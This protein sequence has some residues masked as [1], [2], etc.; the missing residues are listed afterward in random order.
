MKD[1]FP[2]CLAAVLRYEGGYVDNPNDPGGATL[3]GVTQASYDQWRRS[4]GLPIMPVRQ[5][6]PAERDLIYKT[7]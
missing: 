7:R 1:N 4:R 2:A 3:N 6:E 5:M